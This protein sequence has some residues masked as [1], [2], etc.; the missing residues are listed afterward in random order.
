[1]VTFRKT[2]HL[3][4]SGKDQHYPVLRR[5]LVN[6]LSEGRYEEA[7]R[8]FEYLQGT[9]SP[10]RNFLLRVGVDIYMNE[11]NFDHKVLRFFNSFLQ[12]MHIDVSYYLLVLL[13]FRIFSSFKLPQTIM[14]SMVY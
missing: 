9:R 12:K 4:L 14:L 10:N 6:A 1:M 5:M 3:G 2:S 11:V 13:I 8:L 7:K